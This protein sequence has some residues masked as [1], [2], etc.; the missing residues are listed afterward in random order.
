MNCQVKL[1]SPSPKKLKMVI[2]LTWTV[3]DDFHGWLSWMTFMDDFH[4]YCYG[5]L[6]WMNFMDDWTYFTYW[7][8]RDKH[9]D[10]QTLVL[11]MSPLRLKSSRGRL[12]N[13]LYK[14]GFKFCILSDFVRYILN[15]LSYLFIEA[16]D[17]VCTRAAT[18]L[19][20]IFW[21]GMKL[22][23]SRQLGT[24]SLERKLAFMG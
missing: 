15:K 10:G 17:W 8:Q 2:C 7:L 24:E 20:D 12:Y 14:E 18:S 11:V 4:G 5:W 13:E 9:K 3:M 22:L 16:A 1:G 21:L 19:L 6:S 23:T